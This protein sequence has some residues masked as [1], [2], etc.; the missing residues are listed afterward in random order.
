MPNDLRILILEDSTSDAR[1]MELE[2]K[3]AAIPFVS[4]QVEN[5]ESFVEALDSFA[6]DIILSDFALP[7]FDAMSALDIVRN[8]MPDIPMIIV[9]GAIDEET[10]VEC[11]KAGAS[12]YVLKDRLGRLGPALQGAIEKY[13]TRE[14]RR[15]AEDALVS[16][17]V[18]YRR[19]FESAIEG[20]VLVEGEQHTITDMNPFFLNMVGSE[21]ESIMGKSIWDIGI[22]L[23]R[24]VF[25]EAIQSSGQDLYLHFDD[26]K[27]ETGRGRRIMVELSYNNFSA[28]EKIVGQWNIR[29]ITERKQSETIRAQLFQAQKMEAIGTLAGGVAHDFNNVMTAIQVSADLAMMKVAEDDSVY[30]DFKE[31]RYSALRAAGL[32]RQLLLFSR[33]HPVELIV[34]RLNDVVD[35]LTKMLHRL[36]SEDISISM[37]L[38]SDIWS[39]RADISNMEQIVMNLV[40]NARDAMPNGG[41]LLIQTKNVVVDD[42]FCKTMP[43]AREG[44][45]VCISIGDTGIGMSAET[46]ERIFEPFY[47]T[48]EAE[49]GTGLGLA[50]VYG[51]VKQHEG[52]INVNSTLNHG[53]TFQ[54]FLPAVSETPKK[55]KEIKD[56]LEKYFGK[57]E[58]IL[59]VE[60]E[61]KVREFTTKALVKCGYQVTASSTATEAYDL[62]MQ[63]VNLY[64][65]VF[66]DVVLCD[67]NGI[68]LV[69]KLLQIKP[70]I[71]VLL[72]SGYMDQKSQWSII[73]DKGLPFLQ[74]PYALAELLEAIRGAIDKE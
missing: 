16:S 8:K 35:N 23:D 56:S 72:S 18:R 60:D 53:S 36:I 46:L 10:A 21:K 58:K 33:E 59:L 37:E 25:A 69:E 44:Q 34:L 71:R 24:N 31:I 26:L 14:A 20:I 48:K 6:P 3:Q 7:E 43:E 70:E 41:K 55:G 73:V 49:K 28:N 13:K 11:M 1:L 68:D 12:D 30:R 39:V 19:L 50:V 22:S 54:V 62:F 65:L 17:E 61:D 5:E 32:I 66:T 40:L 9:T 42:V 51:I 38:E 64:D 15:Q 57:G 63:D 67:Q 74:K 2:L 47:T 27:F 45:F 4:K 52:W 29:D